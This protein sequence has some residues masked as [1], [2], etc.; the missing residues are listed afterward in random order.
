MVCSATSLTTL[1]GSATQLAAASVNLAAPVGA[2]SSATSEVRDKFK[3]AVTNAL[4]AAGATVVIGVAASW[5]TA[6][7]SNVA[8]GAGVVVIAG[9]TDRVLK[10]V[11]DTSRLI[12]IIGTAAAVAGTTAAVATAFD[13]VPDLTGEAVKLA[14]I[15]AMKVFIDEDDIPYD[16]LTPAPAIPLGG[17]TDAS[18]EYI[19]AKHVE[20][21]EQA[22]N[23]KSTFN[24]GADLDA[25]A[26]AAEGTPARGPNKYG[27]YERIVD[28]GENIG[29]LSKEAGGAATTRYK[30]ITDKYGTV[31]NMFPVK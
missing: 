4:I 6:A 9:N 13:K 17:L 31:I 25:L 10:G 28:A 19:R 5:I 20:G 22:T 23:R 24:G 15:I 16:Q 26:D 1:N 21:G 30:V 12:R 14:A 18:E 7:L 2:Y 11:Y 3:E 29:N 8:A 27:N